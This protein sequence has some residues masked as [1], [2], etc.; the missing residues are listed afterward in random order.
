MW[1]NDFAVGLNLYDITLF[2]LIGNPARFLAIFSLFSSF[3][4]EKSCDT[5]SAFFKYSLP[6]AFSQND[7]FAERGQSSENRNS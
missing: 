6:P 3:I 2:E 7:S 4:S 5:S 1:R